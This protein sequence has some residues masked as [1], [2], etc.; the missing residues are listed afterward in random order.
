LSRLALTGPP[1]PPPAARSG[2]PETAREGLA[3][4]WLGQAG[5]LVESASLRI[6]IDPYLS[7]SLGMKY[8]GTARPH[9]RMSPPPMAPEALCDIDIVLASHG[10]GD[11]LDPLTI[12]PVAAANPD[13]L[14]VVPS[15]CAE[16][17]LSRGVPPERLVE[18]QAF[19]P[20]DVGG[21][22]IHPIPSAHEE[23]AIDDH[24]RLLA[25]GFVL[26]LAGVTIYHSGD[27]APY[28]GLVDNLSPFEV[29]LALLPVNGR[30][31]ERAAA[32]I[33]GNFSLEEAVSLA[34]RAGFAAAIGHHF[35]MFAF[36]TIDEAEAR[37]F[38][39]GR[40]AAPSFLLAEAGLRYEVKP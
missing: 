18:A 25:L 39:G 12:G 26:E 28:P 23:L 7:D 32:G 19:A 22:S 35:G 37:R 24:G 30:D 8:R 4:Y 9:I 17:A 38:L 6:L 5:F 10:H 33:L 1:A 20:L 16:R 34:E 2:A 36:N 3:L 21:L 40:A 13:C 31:S 29:D 15:S 11:H 27:C 14:F